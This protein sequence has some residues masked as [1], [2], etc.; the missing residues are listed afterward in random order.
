MCCLHGSGLPHD[1]AVE[2]HD[3]VRTDDHRIGV[4]CGERCGLVVRIEARQAAEHS[5]RSGVD[6]HEAVDRFVRGDGNVVLDEL[7]FIRAQAAAD[8]ELQHAVV[9]DGLAGLIRAPRSAATAGL[10]REHCQ[11]ARDGRGVD[12]RVVHQL[13]YFSRSPQILG[14]FV[15]RKSQI[16]TDATPEV[17]SVQYRYSSTHFK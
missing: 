14:S 3:R 6:V 11:R 9:G 13:R 7:K 15:S 10:R 1:V 4:R 8:V 2:H 12:A 16:A 5:R 17:F